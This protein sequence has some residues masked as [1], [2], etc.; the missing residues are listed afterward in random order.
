RRWIPSSP[1]QFKESLMSPKAK[2]RS[3]ATKKASAGVKPM[4]LRLA[5][6]S[7]VEVKH[8][9]A[10]PTFV[11]PKKIHPRHLLPLVREGLERGFHSQSNEAFLRPLAM[12][13][14]PAAMAPLAADNELTLVTN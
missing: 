2:S 5:S 1:P 6:R 10:P 11:K 4:K 7:K 9:N 12:A 3:S 14:P 13:L 8:L